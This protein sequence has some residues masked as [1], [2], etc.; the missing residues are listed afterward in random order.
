[1]SPLSNSATAIRDYD[2]R[3]YLH[4][5]EAMWLTDGADR[6]ISARAENIYVW[7]P[8]GKRL[9][10][11]PGG[12]WCTQI[13]YGRRDMADAIAEQVMR[14]SYHSPGTRRASPA[15]CW[16]RSSPTWPPAT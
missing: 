14:L 5:W 3:H 16:R 8:E 11:G 12:M 4:P 10:D 1:M 6:T 7:T 13:G 15:R 9:I 2:N